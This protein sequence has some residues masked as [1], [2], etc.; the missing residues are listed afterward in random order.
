MD[1]FTSDHLQK[2]TT[3]RQTFQLHTNKIGV[4]SV[5]AQIEGFHSAAF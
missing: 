1:C 3:L 2:K 5:H 4:F